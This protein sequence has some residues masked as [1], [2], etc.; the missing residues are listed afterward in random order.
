VPGAMTIAEESTA[1]FGV[2]RPAHEGGLGFTFKWNM[3]WMHD[4]LQY[5]SKEPIH[6]R[7]HQDELTFSMIYE[8]SERFIN[9][10]SHDEVVYGKRQLLDKMPGDIW[11]QFANLRVLLAYQYTRPGKMLLFMGTEVGQYTEWSHDSSVDWSLQDD[12]RR[13]QLQLFM[14]ELGQLYHD[15]PALW[16]GDPDPGS[17][18]W[19]DCSDRKNSVLS[20]VRRHGDD[21]VVVVLNLTPVPRDNYRIGAPEAG[22]YVCR[23]SSDDPRYGGSGYEIRQTVDTDPVPMH[24]RAQSMELRLAPLGAL[25]YVPDPDFETDEAESERAGD[26]TRTRP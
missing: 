16:Q 14:T 4:T 15:T 1:W 8:H 26:A 5:F 7:Y 13:Q 6:R 10:L 24:G 9:S 21:H 2:T 11:Q 18:Q 12:P 3:G 22:R 17:F 19:I 20:Y 23:M 25:I